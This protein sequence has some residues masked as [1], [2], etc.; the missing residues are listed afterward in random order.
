MR[1]DDD[2]LPIALSKKYALEQVK[3]QGW[4]WLLSHQ[5]EFGGDREIAMEAVKNNGRALEYLTK[6][7]RG[8][9][10]IVM[11]AMKTSGHSLQFAT[12]EL[13]CNKEIIDV[14]LGNYGFALEYVNKVYKDDPETCWIAIK[15]DC[16]A[17]QFVSNRLLKDEETLKLFHRTFLSSKGK[18]WDEEDTLEDLVKQSVAIDGSLIEYTTEDIKKNKEIGMIAVKQ[19]GYALEYLHDSL[20]ED[21]DIVLQAIAVSFDTGVHSRV[22]GLKTIK[23]AIRE[24]KDFVLQ[25]YNSNNID[26]KMKCITNSKF[27]PTKEQ[28]EIGLMDE[29]DKIRSIY[30]ER[31]SEWL[32][33]LQENM[34]STFISFHSK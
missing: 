11:E 24:N 29:N 19:I 13:K 32:L 14:A 12:E 3:E 16:M 8:N 18:N 7:L 27:I 20:K 5:K 26:M 10:E 34:T 21:K 28:I 31:K 4:V 9:E 33:K 1:F 23:D 22:A 30:I 15:Q 25:C 17:I 6:E 2:D